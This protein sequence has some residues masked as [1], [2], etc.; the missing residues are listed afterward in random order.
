MGHRPCLSRGESQDQNPLRNRAQAMSE[1]RV[2]PATP[3]SG[4]GPSAPSLASCTV[5][6]V[7][8][9]GGRAPAMLTLFLHAH[10]KPVGS[11]SAPHHLRAH[12]QDRNG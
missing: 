2:S 3:G 9:P 6:A 7:S 1:L 11:M 8:P 5:T 12:L 4:P 10:Q